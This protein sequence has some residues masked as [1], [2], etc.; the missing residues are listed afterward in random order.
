M[1]EERRYRDEE[2]KEILG[3]AVRT[4]E[5]GP[6]TVP[7]EGGLT[8]SELQEVGLEIGVEPGRIAE[9]ALTLQTRREVLPRRT[10]L[11]VP[12]SA[13]RVIELPRALTDREWEVLVGE[14][15]ET[16]GARGHVTSQGGIR[17]WTNGN[18]HVFLE[19]T[20]TGHRLRLGTH[21]GN[22]TALL[23]IGAAGLVF[24]LAL[25]ALFVAEQLG[26][27][28]LVLPVLAAVTGGGI[29]ASN[30]IRLPRWARRR[31]AQ[32]ESIAGRVTAL[33]GESPPGEEA[34]L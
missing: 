6:V 10:F 20:A 23:R 4:H 31:E 15:R 9:A 21:K 32:M 24:G 22:A 26:R 29:L 27:A 7:D 8:L 25:I 30:V 13:G 1:A 3:L 33:L 19:P 2:V 5:V 11:G 34:G 14:F 28:A 12:I 16:F 18:L 17:E